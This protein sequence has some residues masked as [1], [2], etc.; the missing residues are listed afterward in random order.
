MYYMR[1]SENVTLIMAGGSG[2]RLWPISRKLYPKQFLLLPDGTTLL[3]KAFERAMKVSDYKEIFVVTNK[4][5]FFQVEEIFKIANKDRSFNLIQILEPSSRNTAPAIA[6]SAKY[7]S[8]FYENNSINTLVFAS[9]QII[10]NL[11]GFEKTVTQGGELAE[12]DKIVTFGIK[13]E[14]ASTDYGYIKH[15]ENEILQ[16][17]EKPNYETAKKY[18]NSGEYL[19]NSGMFM[20]KLEKFFTEI[21]KYCPALY[22][23]CVA[24]KK[25]IKTMGKNHIYDKDFYDEM[26]D[27]SIDYALM[28]KTKSG[29]VV[30]SMF[31]WGDFGNLNSFAEMI[32]PDHDGNRSSN[33]KNI[34]QDSQNVSIISE[35]VTI[36]AHG[37]SNLLIVQTKDAVLV[38]EKNKINSISDIY[39]RIKKQ[40]RDLVESHREVHRPWGK[41]DSI[42][43]GQG[44][45][46]KRITVKPGQKLSVQSHKHRSE[47]WVVVSGRAKIHYGEE[48]FE[49]GVNESTYHDKEVVHALE[50]PYDE[51]LILIEVQIGDYVGEDDIIRYSDIYGRS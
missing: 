3:E 51:E 35:D 34:V 13:P 32:E 22:E 39:E 41:Y 20:F 14:F 43:N 23:K 27:I 50:N 16:F 36:C 40:N 19:W 21:K 48:S 2:K 42:D 6:L 12:K 46:V 1:M 8:D 37:L 4:D 17:V 25:Y 11:D 7:I 10:N 9:D 44:F 18:I 15:K 5:Y 30:K 33:K 24:S 28:E 38:V 26:E 29:A 49:I 45:Q 47:H 31:D